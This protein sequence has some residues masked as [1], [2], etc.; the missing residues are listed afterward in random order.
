MEEPVN[1]NIFVCRSDT[2]KY[3]ITPI[4]CCVKNFEN[5]QITKIT[6]LGCWK[7]ENDKYICGFSPLFCCDKTDK[8]I[9]YCSPC[10]F[11]REEENKNCGVCCCFCNYKNYFFDPFLVESLIFKDSS[12]KTIVDN[13]ENFCSI[14]VCKFTEKKYLEGNTDNFELDDYIKKNNLRYKKIFY[15]I[16]PISF[17]KKYGPE[18]QK[19]TDLEIQNKFDEEI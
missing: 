8:K 2:K 7:M 10:H 11:S 13:T 1:C 16:T 15:T 17:S 5:N 4:I 6:P 3:T 9:I 14:C 12:I 19:M 18:I